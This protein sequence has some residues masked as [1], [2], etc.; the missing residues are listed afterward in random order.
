MIDKLCLEA[1]IG[2]IQVQ[3]MQDGYGDEECI[4]EGELIKELAQREK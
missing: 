3:A 1:Q 2:E 4:K